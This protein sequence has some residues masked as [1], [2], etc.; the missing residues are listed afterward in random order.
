MKM[1][2]RRR[3]TGLQ[4]IEVLIAMAIG[5]VIALAI[6]R[7]YMSSF[8]IQ[9]SQM[10][11]MRLNETARFAFS[12][13]ERELHQAGFS[14]SW[15]AVNP[16]IRFCASN[17]AGSSIAGMNDVSGTIDPASSDFSG[18]AFSVANKSDVVRVSYNGED[19]TQTAPLLDCHGYPVAGGT[20]VQDTLFVHTDPATGEPTLY[21]DTSNP[22]GNGSPRVLPLVTGVESLQV[23]YGLDVDAD[24]IVDRYVPWNLVNSNTDLINSVR[25]SIVVRSPSESGTSATSTI[26]NHF[27]ADAYPTASKS[28]NSDS[29]ATFTSPTD[30]RLRTISTTEVS[31]RNFSYCTPL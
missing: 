15:A 26:F 22:H 10:D 27:G 19:T 4:L 31:M 20:T 21:C 29:G 3:Q 11:T 24:G 17:A 13:L 7:A 30:K 16:A 9:S 12:L 6:T 18:S 14:N 28:A 1:S 25:L 8:R 5:S 23:L 2:P